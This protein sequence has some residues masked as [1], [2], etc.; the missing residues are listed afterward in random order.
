MLPN[1]ET[2]T[3]PEQNVDST[4]LM[5][6][7]IVSPAR[8]SKPWKEREIARKIQTIEVCVFL[9]L[10][11]PTEIFYFFHPPTKSGLIE[12]MIATALM[13]VGLGSLVIF[14]A[15]RNKE[16]LSLFGLTLKNFWQELGLG[17]GLFAPFIIGMGV[18]ELALKK[19]GLH[20][21]PISSSFYS[22]PDHGWQTLFSAGV[23]VAIIVT[24][25]ELIFR[26]YL[27]RRFSA[28]F[29]SLSI[30]FILSLVIFAFGHGYEGW[31]GVITVGAGGAVF[32]LVY[33]WRRSLIAPIVMHFLLD[34]LAIVLAPLWTTPK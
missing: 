25:E 33:L 1:N 28:V 32:T 4:A 13:D 30:A 12:S 9:L 14:F 7:T 24:V 8:A 6:I 3:D 18:L 15:W 16:K 19:L 34:F 21:K 2:H 11:I 23:A 22:L 10:I 20:I 26:G 5:P 29:K 17:V 27:L 31:G